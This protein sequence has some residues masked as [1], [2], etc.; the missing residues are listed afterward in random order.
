MKYY[1]KVYEGIFDPKHYTQ[2]G[3]ALWLYTFLLMRE[4]YG[5]VKQRFV[6]SDAELAGTIGCGERV[7][8]DW[9]KR[10]VDYAYIEATRHSHGYSYAIRKSKKFTPSDADE[11]TRSDRQKNVNHSDGVI[12][13]K[14]SGDRQKS[15]MNSTQL[16]DGETLK[17]PN[18]L[19]KG[20]TCSTYTLYDPKRVW[21]RQPQKACSPANPPVGADL[22]DVEIDENV[23]PGSYADVAGFDTLSQHHIAA[24][25]R[26]SP[27]NPL[28]IAGFGVSVLD[29][30][31][32]GK[33]VHIS[34]DYVAP[35]LQVAHEMR[36][37][38]RR[39]T[40]RRQS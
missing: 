26:G 8:R 1:A 33:E 5:H 9:R 35:S 37:L 21:N 17:P 18:K 15:V 11:V 10:L 34:H 20:K 19:I 36:R 32:D 25:N 23:E 12:D 30:T 39:T 7:I 3:P 38:R 29:I 31:P 27:L 13:V 28:E 14:T 40:Q 2:I 24:G 22:S 4:T 6:I 16:I